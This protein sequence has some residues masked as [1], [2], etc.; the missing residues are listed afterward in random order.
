[1]DPKTY[2]EWMLRTAPPTW[3]DEAVPQ[4]EMAQGLM[5]M[6]AA[7][8]A[9]ESIARALF[10]VN[11]P[12]NVTQWQQD[13]ACIASLASEPIERGDGVLHYDRIKPGH[14]QQLHAA[15]GVMTEA[16]ELSDL[17]Y[18]AVIRNQPGDQL[19]LWREEWGDLNWFNALGAHAL[20]SPLDTVIWPGNIRKLVARYP[21]KFDAEIASGE[22]DYAAEREAQ[23]MVGE[24]VVADVEPMTEHG[25]GGVIL[26]QSVYDSL[27]DLEKAYL[28][29]LAAKS[30]VCDVMTQVADKAEAEAGDASPVD[31]VLS[32]PPELPVVE[33]R[34]ASVAFAAASEHFTRTVTK[35]HRRD[36]AA[37]QQVVWKYRSVLMSDPVLVRALWMCWCAKHY[38]QQEVEWVSVTLNGKAR[39]SAILA[40]FDYFIET[41]QAEETEANG[42]QE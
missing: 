31:S 21:D 33:R 22:R 32:E 39:T 38:G 15:L 40:A 11:A 14:F 19:A 26:R 29:E 12:F 37:I 4:K 36:C 35:A 10:Y 24:A 6:C 5:L 41:M 34:D 25:P 28:G 42:K 13:M 3:D 18:D 9:M 8:V 2:A 1:M 23:G 27:N 30:K 7:G 17:L 20:K 16:G